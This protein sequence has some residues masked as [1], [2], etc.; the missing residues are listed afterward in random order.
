MF[1]TRTVHN[2]VADISVMENIC[3]RYLMDSSV[4]NIFICQASS[5]AASTADRYGFQ[6]RELK[7]AAEDDLLISVDA[8]DLKTAEKVL[9]QIV[10]MA[11]AGAGPGAEES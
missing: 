9:S 8:S 7:A 1:F 4:D 2:C 6:E 5:E 3:D 11:Q 10:S